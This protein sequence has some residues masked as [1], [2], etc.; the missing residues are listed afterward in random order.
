[1]KAERDRQEKEILSVEAVAQVRYSS[2][3]PSINAS[4]LSIYFM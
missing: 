2:L 1:M 4:E 3:I